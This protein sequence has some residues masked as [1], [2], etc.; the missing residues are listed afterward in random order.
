MVDALN[1]LHTRVSQLEALSPGWNPF[2]G[3]SKEEAELIRQMDERLKKL[4]TIQETHNNV[5]INYINGNLVMLHA[6]GQKYLERIIRLE[7]YLNFTPVQAPQ[8]P[9]LPEAPRNPGPSPPPFAPGTVPPGQATV[10]EPP[11]APG[12]DE[13]IPSAIPVSAARL[14][15][16]R[17]RY[18]VFE[19]EA[20]RL[21]R[22]QR[23]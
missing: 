1:L 18:S 15:T 2:A 20:D 3:A 5:W 6:T 19:Q 17:A 7:K 10:P 16:M 11:S 14:R 21:R 13:A 4:E 23:Q 8:P 12:Q 9:A 22:A